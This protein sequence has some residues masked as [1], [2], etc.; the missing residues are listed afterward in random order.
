MATRT[1][2]SALEARRLALAAQGFGAVRP[3]AGA[4]APWAAVHRT[5]R[6]LGVIQIDSVNVLAR[7]HYLPAFSRLGGYDREVFDARAFGPPGRGSGSGSGPGRGRAFFEYWAHEASLLPLD[8]HPALRWRM[9]R[10]EAGEGVYKSVAAFGRERRDVVDAVV[11]E[12]TARGPLSAGEIGAAEGQRP[13]G[14]GGWWGWSEAKTALEYLFWAGRVTTA[15]RRGFERVYDLTERVIPPAILALPTLD[16]AAA[17]R[18]L[19][20]HAAASLGVAAETDLRDYFRLKPGPARAALGELV[21][22]G[23]L[24]PV[25]VE[26]WD[27]PAFMPPGARIPRRMAAHALVS[28]F[29]PLVW[30]RARTL[31]LF[32][33]HYRIEIYTPAEKRQFGYYVLPFLMGDRLVARVDLKAD[34]ATGALQ[35]P[36]SHL[37]AGQAAGPVAEALA[38]E[39][40][41]LAHWLG[42]DRV[43]VAPKGD[44]AKA[45]AAAVKR[46]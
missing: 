31:R 29:D 34:R 1:G 15:F 14:A 21:E 26:G 32:D 41:R 16:E 43:E 22:A 10:A 19:M 25:V 7:A 45:L 28:P 36:A 30:E 20:A 27:V 23:A 4:V 5:A 24:A 42:L 11:A 17:H 8:L 38:A 44:L 9:A 46:R 33:F 40:A 6:A 35:V 13:R 3:E 39:L 37:E 18:L 12:I 2:I